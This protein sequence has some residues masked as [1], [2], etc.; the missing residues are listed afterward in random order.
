MWGLPPCSGF[1]KYVKKNFFYNTIVLSKTSVTM[2]LQ[3]HT[4]LVLNIYLQH[5]AV[6]GDLC[7]LAETIG[8]GYIF[9]EMTKASFK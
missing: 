1:F 3:S 7:D 4:E 2:A 6:N 9:T 8:D 5:L